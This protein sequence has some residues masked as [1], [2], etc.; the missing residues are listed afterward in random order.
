MLGK[1]LSRWTLAWFASAL[2]F[3]LAA[4]VLACLGL[5]GPG[6]WSGAGALGAVHLFAIGWLCQMMLGS[7]IQFVPVLTARP[8]VLPRL[9]LPAL[10]LCSL[11]ALMLAGGFWALEGRPVGFLLAAGPVLLGLAFAL[12]G[13]ML[14]GTLGAAR[15]WR[16]QD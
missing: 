3:L 14:G 13:L 10:I 9:A 6:R 11:G 12:A 5:A 15:A 8:L 7:L 4:L 16:G 2:A 1:A